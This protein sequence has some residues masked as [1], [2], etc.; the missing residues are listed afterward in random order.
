MAETNHPL[1][2]IV[3]DEVLAAKELRARSIQEA[4]AL[5]SGK[6]TDEKLYTK[7]WGS[8]EYE[9]GVAKPGKE[10]KREVP[11][12]NDMLPYIRKSGQS[13]TL[14][15]ASF[16]DIFREIEHVAGKSK[17]ALE[18]L[19]CLLIRSAYMLDH[20]VEGERVVYKPPQTIVE[21]IEKEIPS[22]FGVPFH[23][24]IQYLDA[25]ALN[26]DV[27]YYTLGL[28]KEKP[29]GPDAGRKNNLLTCAHLIA[30]LM[31]KTGVIDFGYRFAQRRGVSPLSEA[32]AR[33]F[34]PHLAIQV[35][36]KKQSSKNTK[37][38]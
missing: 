8:G 12:V 19:G 32:E 27:K 13:A 37:S 11:N 34:F 7:L 28:T 36:V 24:F 1:L 16:L 30:H 10:T 38:R 2:K 17:S 29:Y 21:A 33:L 5:P 9:V 22:L 4:I 26:E 35:R 25:I 3:R 15:D 18:L 20:E 23:V 14:K 6:S 31:Q